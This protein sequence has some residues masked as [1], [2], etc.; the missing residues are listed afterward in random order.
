MIPVSCYQAPSWTPCQVWILLKILSLSLLLPLSP[1]HTPSLLYIHTYLHTY[2]HTYRG[3]LSPA[4]TGQ[5]KLRM[6]LRV[7]LCTGLCRASEENSYA[8]SAFFYGKVAVLAGQEW[9]HETWDRSMGVRKPE[10][11]DTLYS[12]EVPLPGDAALSPC[13]NKLALLAWRQNNYF[14]WNKFFTRWHLFSS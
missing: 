3:P 14:S 8:S 6:R 13:Q 10:T 9:D 12:S 5:T 11:V 1:A 2:I 7:W 4:A